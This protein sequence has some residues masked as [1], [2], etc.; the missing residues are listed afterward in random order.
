MTSAVLSTQTLTPELLRAWAWHRQGLDGSLSGKTSEEVL[1]RAGWARSVGGANPYLTLFARAGIRREQVDRDVAE[2]RIHELPTARGCTYVLGRND[3]AWGLQVGRDAAVAP[4]KVLARLGVERGE[5]TLL[6]EQVLHTLLE[7]SDPMDPKQLRD[8][9]GESVRSLGEEGK[10]KGASTTLPTA[11]GLLQ[12][13]G[14]IR[15]VPVNGRL[16]QQRY[17]YTSWVLPPSG[18][19]DD[20][21]RALLIERYL[22]WTGGATFKQSQWLTGFTVA[23]S[24]AAL[25]AVGAVEVTTAAGEPLWMLPDD[26]EHLSAFTAPQEEQ[27]QLLAGTDSLVLLRRNSADMLAEGDRGRKILDTTLA[28]QADLSDHPIL[29]RGRIIGLW[30]YDPGKERIAA[31]TFDKPTAAVTQRINEVESWIREDLG[32][33]RSF[34]LDSPASR[35]KRID[36]LDSANS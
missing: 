21:A 11:L 18:L 17:A 2:L 25:A 33:F 6:E 36:A 31:W 19:D 35:Q 15:R 28:L 20:A 24:K 10:K 12:A 27:I 1:D 13:D 14:R 8:E 34:S 26:V 4:F 9:L 29:D 3:F 32:D 7:S 22:R 30:Q 16:D 5:I 23:Q